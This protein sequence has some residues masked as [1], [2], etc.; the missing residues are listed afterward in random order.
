MN[1]EMPTK[2]YVFPCGDP[3]SHQ[4]H[5]SLGPAAA[6][7]L[8][9][10]SSPLPKMAWSGTRPTLNFGTSPSLRMTKYKKGHGHTWHTLNSGAIITPPQ[11]LKKNKQK[12]LTSWLVGI[13]WHWRRW[14]WV[15][16]CGRVGWVGCRWRVWLCRI[17]Y[18][19][20]SSWVWRWRTCSWGVWRRMSDTIASCNI[21][22]TQ[23]SRS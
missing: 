12:T 21:N 10:Y 5:G 8:I 13:R 18:G 2:N 17:W 22:H 20:R 1:G 14:W 6:A 16:R 4:T 19:I 23:S 11:Q 9:G 7:A 3:G 15:C